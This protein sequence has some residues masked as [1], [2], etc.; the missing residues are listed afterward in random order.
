MNKLLCSIIIPTY[1]GSETVMLAVKSALKQ[2][3]IKPEI[4]VVDDNGIGS[5][6]QK[7]TENVLHGYIQNHKIKYICHDVNRNGSAARNTGLKLAQG[8]YISFLDDDDWLKPYKCYKQI[9]V[10]RQNKDCAMCVCS[11]CY[12]DIDGVGYKKRIHQDSEFMYKYLLDKI[13]FNTSAI[14]FRKKELLDICGFDESFK[15]HQDW[16]LVTR[17]LSKFKAC[18]LSD[19]EIIRYLEGRNNP[20][21]YDQRIENLEYFLKK[22]EP[23]MQKK[24]S[25]KKVEKVKLYRRREICQAMIKN[26]SIKKANNYGKT[27][28]G[29]FEFLKSF[30]LMAPLAFRKIVFGRKK[31][32]PK[33]KDIK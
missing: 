28:G 21:N 6:E 26:G 5:E 22:C 12:V 17:F 27:Y 16:E 24:M 33:K 7:K 25:R 3:K 23:Y 20:S 30:V 14:M 18:T 29:G 15:R 13:Y 4:I 19:V 31:V 8:Y 2:K 32:A 1:K 9:C 10:L 11:G